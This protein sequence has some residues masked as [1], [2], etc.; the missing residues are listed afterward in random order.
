M[1]LKEEK[2]L[3]VG[4]YKGSAES[5]ISISQTSDGSCVVGSISLS[6]FPYDESDVDHDVEAALL[7]LAEME[8]NDMRRKGTSD[9][10]ELSKD[11]HTLLAQTLVSPK[12]LAAS[13]EN[14]TNFCNTSLENGRVN[15]CAV[16]FSPRSEP[17]FDTKRALEILAE[18]ERNETRHCDD[19]TH[20]SKL[21]KEDVGSILAV[22]YDFNIMTSD[23]TVDHETTGKKRIS[24]QT[25]SLCLTPSI[26][27]LSE[28]VDIDIDED[29]KRALQIFS[30]ME[31]KENEEDAKRALEILAEMEEEEKRRNGLTEGVS[32]SIIVDSP[33]SFNYLKAYSGETNSDAKHIL[34]IVGAT[35]KDDDA[36]HALQVLG[37]MER[38][39]KWKKD[40][41][42]RT[43]S[44]DVSSAGALRENPRSFSS[45]EEHNNNDAAQI[46]AFMEN[47]FEN[48]KFIKNESSQF[49]NAEPDDNDTLHAIHLMENEENV[50]SINTERSNFSNFVSFRE[51][52]TYCEETQ[53]SAQHALLLLAE[54]EDIT[55]LSNF[56]ADTTNGV[57]N[58][59]EFQQ[60]LKLLSN[61]E[62]DDETR[63]ALEILAQLEGKTFSSKSEGEGNNLQ[64]TLEDVSSSRTYFEDNEADANFALQILAEME[65]KEKQLMY[66]NATGISSYFHDENQDSLSNNMPPMMD[67][68]IEEIIKQVNNIISS[69]LVK[70]G[71]QSI[72]SENK[73]Q[74]N[75]PT[76]NGM[77]QFTEVNI[78]DSSKSS[79][80]DETL[81][82][83]IVSTPKNYI[84]DIEQIS[85]RDSVPISINEQLEL[86]EK[87]TETSSSDGI[88]DSTKIV[89]VQ[90]ENEKNTID[91]ALK[92]EERPVN[93]TVSTILLSGSPLNEPATSDASYEES[94]P[95]P[96]M[97]E[98]SE[99]SFGFDP[100]KDSQ[101][102]SNAS[103]AF[104]MDDLREASDSSPL[105]SARTT[106][107]LTTSK[108]HGVTFHSPFNI[109]DNA[110]QLRSES[111]LISTHSKALDPLN[112]TWCQATQ[113][114][115]ELINAVRGASNSRRCNA[116]GTFKMLTFNDK[117]KITLARTKGVLDA[118]RFVIELKPSL[119]CQY[120][121]SSRI[122][123][124]SAIYNLSTRAENREL[125]V[126]CRLLPGLI[127][128]VKDDPPE[129]RLISC[130]T[131]ALLAKSEMNQLVMVSTPGLLTVL[132][133]VLAA[134]AG[135]TDVIKKAHRTDNVF[136]VELTDEESEDQYSDDETYS[137]SGSATDETCES[138]DVSV[139]DDK[140]VGYTSTQQEMSMFLNP[141]RVC[142]CAALIHLSKDCACIAQMCKSSKLLNTLALVCNEQDFE[143]RT[144]S[145]E[146]LCNLTRFPWNQKILASNENVM[147][148]L[149]KCLKS[150]SAC[151][152]KWAA[153]A[154][155]NICSDQSSRVSIAK[156]PLLLSLG[157]SALS[158]EAEE[159]YAAVAALLNLSCEPGVVT[160]MI[161]TRNVVST[162]IHLT[163]D[164]S[165]S[166][167]VRLMSC[168]ALASIGMWLQT[169]AITANV[170]DG[171][172]ATLP[173]SIISGWERYE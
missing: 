49:L 153:R 77:K 143:A 165:T 170:P 40:L 38:K 130:S 14:S 171:M 83:K 110:P 120:A 96:S 167:E 54:M 43:I 138:S 87:L 91:D 70:N 124:L 102:I 20:F 50:K 59:S 97:G 107:S 61:M 34:Q 135:G 71:D 109:P 139:A 44:S 28:V 128:A 121:M 162:L 19:T 148:S 18:M 113:S 75:T 119:S 126:H 98:C 73:S 51:R 112:V 69:D 65:K 114:V 2:G 78:H 95:L 33:R 10:L 55:K 85:E 13:T 157:L 25:K 21:N 92:S 145:I 27:T 6:D 115:I 158:D 17:D 122:R 42:I 64:Q 72:V 39:E 94:K 56:P 108:I 60:A 9:C 47:E 168:D 144:K 1:V 150:T 30:E 137:S 84:P 140:Y 63:H 127:N 86:M 76:E 116:C 118:F 37:E 26:R 46:L 32:S 5:N 74:V 123:I 4:S 104:S 23:S 8:E 169:V 136:E 68:D 173:T 81:S 125:I 41:T 129:G 103:V 156:Q 45:A 147:Q 12:A 99:S 67:K 24:C 133:E 166:A 88:K 31:T 36:E 159:Q 132:S 172:E 161:N 160:A 7:I 131:L 80:K 15:P 11:A 58:D 152:R 154:L 142:A 117:N 53:G 141:A 164:N 82:G 29:A 93:T 101:S 105:N 35:E 16:N 149:I 134:T 48:M 90:Q 89:T 100:S 146:V 163:Y 52:A 155:Q 3:Q 22:N 106:N 111:E 79:C 151:D 57:E 62:N 66:A